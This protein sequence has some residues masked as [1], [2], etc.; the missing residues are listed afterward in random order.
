MI[1]E[2][3]EL[4]IVLEFKEGKVIIFDEDGNICMVFSEVYERFGNLLIK[5][6]DEVIGGMWVFGVLFIFGCI[7][8]LV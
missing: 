5:K 7:L 4:E 2:R 3:S 6:W 1:E 8:K